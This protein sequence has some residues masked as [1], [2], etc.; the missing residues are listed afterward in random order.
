MRVHAFL[1]AIL[2]GAVLADPTNAQIPLDPSRDQAV[3][4][5]VGLASGTGISYQ[6]ILPSAFGFR[7]AILAW[8]NGD[9][10]FLDLGVSGLRVL[11]DDGR[12]RV[13]LVGSIGCWRRS[14]EEADVEFD[15]QG[16]VVT[17]RVFDDVDDSGAL[18]LGA[19]VELPLGRSAAVSLEGVFTY[20]TDSG[21]LIPVPQASLH[22]LF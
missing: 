10:S 6:E 1:L 14:D 20:W 15:D 8:K 21:D 12:R 19:G 17:E 9:S 5:T 18:G 2:A 22:W 3:G 4:A 11:S 7:V 16:N 13:Y